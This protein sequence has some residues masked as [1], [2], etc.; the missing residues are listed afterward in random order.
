MGLPHGRKAFLLCLAGLLSALPG[1]S[2]ATPQ[3]STSQNPSATFSLPGVYDV[4]LRACN[5]AGCRDV[6]KKV[7]VLDPMP[8]ITSLT[9]PARVGADLVVPLQATTSGR[10]S[11]GHKWIFTKGQTTTEL[12][13][14]PLNWNALAA[15]IGTYQVRLQVT[16]VDGSVTS[17]PVTVQVV[18]HSFLDVPIDHWAW[19][20]IEALV[21]RGVTSGCTPGTFCPD[22]PVTRGQMAVYLLRAK[23]GPLFFPPPC[24]TQQFN[25]VPCSDPFASWINELVARGIT[26]GCGNGNYCPG[27]SVTREQMAVFLLVM[28]EGSGY[29]PPACTTSLFFDVPCSDPFAPWVNELVARGITAGCGAGNFCSRNVVTRAQMSV[30]LTRMFNLPTP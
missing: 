6:T 17:D 3:S 9:V 27:S 2:Q 14:N 19:S 11:L 15:G 29:A 20:F 21:A 1:L 23:E 28:Q 18:P 4:T 22:D 26:A 8:K 10:P 16:N 30:F 12:T 13:G 24:T 25:D 5:E 7:T